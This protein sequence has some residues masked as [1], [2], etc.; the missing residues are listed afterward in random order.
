[1]NIGGYSDY[2]CFTIPDVGILDKHLGVTLCYFQEVSNIGIEGYL[3]PFII[4]TRVGNLYIDFWCYFGGSRGR[5][6]H[7]A[8]L[9]LGCKTPYKLT[10]S[11]IT[12]MEHG[13][14]QVFSPLVT[15][16]HR[17]IVYFIF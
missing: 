14:F 1:M 8:A 9:V 11:A 5:A 10:S 7:A 15:I 16:S 17:K 12:E 4:M 13:S 2:F 3:G 6:A